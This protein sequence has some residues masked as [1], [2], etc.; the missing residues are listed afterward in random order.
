VTPVLTTAEPG[1]QSAVDRPAPIW[2]ATT[3]P[4]E[5]ITELAREFP[6]GLQD[7]ANRTRRATG[8]FR[9]LSWLATFPGRT[10]QAR[11]EACGAEQS[12]TDW[13]EAPTRH[14]LDTADRPLTLKGARNSTS[15]G[16][17]ALLWL[18]VIRPG[19]EFLFASRFKQTYRYFRAVTDPEFF[20]AASS[21]CAHASRRE[22]HESD[23]LNHLSRIVMHT[24]RSPRD[25][26]PDD[27]LQYHAAV[28]RT[29]QA[30]SMSLTWDVLR[31]TGV[32]PS[33]TPPL[34][35]VRQRGQRTVTEMV[36]SYDVV[37]Q[38]VREVLIR[39]LNERAPSL[40]YS[41]L[42]G[43]AGNLVGAFWKDLE[44]HHPGISSL[45]LS[46]EAARGWRERAL[47]RRGHHLKGL[48][49]M[50]P[51]QVL[52]VVRAFYLDIAQ[53]ALNDP[54]WVPWAAPSPVR[55]ADVRGS[56]KHQR[57]RR[58]RMHRRTRT[59]APQLPQ[60]V[61][62]V[63][64]RLRYLE[65]LQAAASE[66][67][68]GATFAI[69]GDQFERIQT[70][71]EARGLPGARRLRVRRLADGEHLDLTRDEEDAFW[72]WAVVETLRHTGVRIEELLELTHLALVTYRMPDSGE[73]VPLLQILP[74]KQDSERV[75]LISP[76]LAHVLA[77]IVHRVRGDRDYVPLVARFDPHERVTG[78]PLPHL[79]QRWHAT[80]RRV[81]TA[82]AVAR[83]L[84]GAL[85]RLGLRGPDGKP[86]HYTPHDF[87]R[88]FATEA[89]GSGLPIHIA[90]KLLGHKD[91]NTT[92]TYTAVYQDDVLRHHAA[93]ISR[94]RATR[95]GEEYREPTSTEWAE[96]GRHFT[97]RKV[98]LGTCAR[99]YATPCR[100][101]HACLRCP[102]LQPDPTQAMRLAEI[103]T[104]IHDR[105]REAT[106]RGWLGEVEGLKVSL[107]GARQKLA[108]MRRTRAQATAIPL[109]PPRSRP[110]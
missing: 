90:A 5:V 67:P 103:I 64:A 24:G 3:L 39:Y 74:S 107:D 73:V 40:D 10:W 108:H 48:A 60:L 94:R 28:V 50:D 53:W 105:L 55:E 58:D 42:R 89:V 27:V 11:W 76:E 79:F 7:A 83:L 52:F 102:M 72:T 49:R 109:E 59:L 23:M 85:E 80:E 33:D 51:F 35:V 78:A 12:L 101:E 19:Y 2:E 92:Q 14:V 99:P 98:E 36:D 84:R 65:R 22:H 44:E 9:L 15:V 100:H 29:R 6:A 17:S 1:M 57:R 43:L 34:R 97:R 61:H 75:L 25:L 31:T 91:I 16:L 66:A 88:I 20:A 37:C 87:R 8:T 4:I 18:G 56:M 54:D 32:F 106:E 45:R 38:P 96:F 70:L 62:S 110:A 21:A 26:R 86:L 63:E 71:A 47:L 77:R 95:P 81:M 93:F 82:T 30:T 68:V 46:P 41:S 104:N 69:D 13:R